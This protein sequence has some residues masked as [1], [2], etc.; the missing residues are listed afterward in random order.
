MTNNY[1]TNPNMKKVTILS[2]TFILL[3][4]FLSTQLAYAQKGRAEQ[5]LEELRTWVDTKLNR[6][7]EVTREDRAQVKEQFN[8][9]AAKVEE[10]ASKLSEQSKADYKDLRS[11]YNQ[12]EAKQQDLATI[13]LDK[14]E[15]A[16]WQAQLL[17]PH[18]NIPKIKAANLRDAYVTFIENVRERRRAWQPEDWVYAE[19]VLGRLNDRKD[20]VEPSLSTREIIKIQAV[21]TEFGTLQAGRKTKDL[22]KEMK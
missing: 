2:R 14:E 10:G 3:V 7:G 4:L 18:Q 19:E 13:Y 12:W 20:Q 16:R 5:D 1:L 21:R 6:A 22:Y 9:L 11:R 15:L 8:R 17:G